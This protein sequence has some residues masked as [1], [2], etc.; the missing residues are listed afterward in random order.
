[1]YVLLCFVI[2]YF[3]KFFLLFFFLKHIFI[4]KKL[5]YTLSSDMLSFL[6]RWDYCWKCEFDT[7]VKIDRK[8][9]PWWRTIR[10]LLKSTSKHSK[11]MDIIVIFILQEMKN[12]NFV[13][14]NC[15]EENVNAIWRKLREM[16]FNWIGKLQVRLTTFHMYFLREI[17][18][19][20]FQ[21]LFGMKK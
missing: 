4:I 14:Q 20:H 15:A 19:A 5:F 12:S 2:T 11:K 1:M 6:Y 21:S 17:V 3:P 9:L 13:W 10:F 18:L 16:K 8:L 7:D